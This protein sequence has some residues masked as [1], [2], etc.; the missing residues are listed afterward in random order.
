ME[1]SNRLGELRERILEQMLPLLET[2]SAPAEERFQLAMQLAGTK[3]TPDFYQKAFDIAQGIEGEGKLNAYFDLL[4]RVDAQ[5][6]S[7]MGDA[8]EDTQNPAA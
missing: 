1:D 4:A 3:G 6:Q 8:G 7:S 2:S 5:L